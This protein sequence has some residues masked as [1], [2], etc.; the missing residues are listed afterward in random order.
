LDDDL[1]L[2]VGLDVVEHLVVGGIGAHFRKDIQAGQNLIAIDGSVEN[3]LA[4]RGE[5]GL[6]EF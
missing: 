4:R 5:I 6:G 3:P 2:G 1:S